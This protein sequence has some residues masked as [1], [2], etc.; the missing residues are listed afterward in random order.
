MIIIRNRLLPLPQFA[1]INICG[2]L[3]CRPGARLTP[4]L[5]NHER[6]HT[7]QIVEM[8]F[9]FFYLWYVTEWVVRLIMRGRAYYNISFEREAYLHE[10]D[11]HYLERRRHFAWWKYMKH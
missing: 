10:H 9:L 3:F 1:A 11:F 7:A 8:A 5:I 2:V 4:R 6:I